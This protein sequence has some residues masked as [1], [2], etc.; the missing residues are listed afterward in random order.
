MNFLN[1]MLNVWVVL[2]LV[3]I[4]D[5]HM[6]ILNWQKPVLSAAEFS[7]NIENQYGIEKWERIGPE[8]GPVA[9]LAI[10]SADKDEIFV[11]NSGGIFKSTDGG[12]TWQETNSGI[13]YVG[14]S[15][16]KSAP[17]SP[18]TIYAASNN[19]LFKSVDSGLT[20][21]SI[22]TNWHNSITAIEIDPVN[23][24]II[25]IGLHDSGV[26]KSSD[27]GETWE[28][29]NQGL[30]NINVTSLSIDYSSLI[31]IYVG[32]DGG[33]VFVSKNDGESWTSMNDGLNMNVYSLAVDCGTSD[34]SIYA[35]TAGGVYKMTNEGGWTCLLQKSG[36]IYHNVIATHPTNADIVY[37]GSYHTLYKS[38]DAGQNW[39]VIGDSFGSIDGIGLHPDAPDRILI[40]SYQGIF[41]NGTDP[42]WI[43][44]KTG[45]T[46]T[47]V[48][49]LAFD[50][51]SSG[52]M[53]SATTYNGLL[54]TTDE[55]ESWKE[56]LDTYS[57]VSVAIDPVN[58]NTLFAATMGNGLYKSTNGGENWSEIRPSNN[59]VDDFDWIRQIVVGSDNPLNVYAGTD[60][61]IL[62]STDGGQNWSKP[63]INTSIFALALHS[64]KPEII[65]SGG[66]DGI[67]FK[68]TDSGETWDAGTELLPDESI[69]IW[70]LKIHPDEPDIIYACASIDGLFLSQDAGLNWRRVTATRAG[71][72]L[73]F[74]QEAQ[75]DILFIASGWNGV[76]KSL[77][78]GNNWFYEGLAPVF[79]RN[80]EKN[81]EEPNR[82]YAGTSGR[83]ISVY[84]HL[85]ASGIISGRVTRESDSQPIENFQVDAYSYDTGDKVFS[86]TFK[87][88][89]G[90][91]RIS[92]FPEGS[93]L[94]KVSVNDTNYISKYY[95]NVVNSL[96]ATPVI[97]IRNETTAGIDFS[98]STTDSTPPEEVTNLRVESYETSAVLKW[99]HSLD[100]EGD[101]AAY[102]VYFGDPAVVIT[103]DPSLNSFEFLNLAASSKQQVTIATIDNN[104][105]ESA[106]VSII[107]ATLLPNPGSVKAEEVGPQVE[108]SWNVVATE[109][110]VKQYAIYVSESDFTS[111]EGM[112]PR[113]LVDGSLLTAQIASL[114]AGTKYYFAVTA[115]NMS[116]ND[117]KEVTTVSAT[118]F[119]DILGPALGEIIMNNVVL[120]EGGK[121]IKGGSLTFMVDDV[122][123]VSRVDL[124]IDEV[125][126]A[127]DTS[128]AAS[129]QFGWDLR[130]IA[131]GDHKLVIKAYDSLG[132]ETIK[133][134]NIVI[135]LAAP[136]TAPT[137]IQPSD[138]TLFISPETLVSGQAEP[139]SDIILFFNNIESPYTGLVDQDGNFSLTAII[140][141]GENKIQALARNRAGDGPLSNEVM[142]SVD[143]TYPLPPANL[144]AAS[145][146]FGLI[147]LSWRRP[148]DSSMQGF[149]LYRSVSD[150]TSPDQ[151]D[152]L[153]SNTLT[154]T[155]Y[156][157][158][159]ASEGTYIYR[160]T[161]IDAAGRESELSDPVSAT[162]DATAP[163]VVAVVYTP[164][165]PYDSATGRT[166]PGEVSST[167]TLNE[168]LISDPFFSINPEGGTPIPVTLEKVSDLEYEGSFVIGP[169]T[170]TG[171]AYAVF[172]G[173]DL[174]GNRGIAINTGA[175][176]TIDT[177][178]PPLIE[179]ELQPGQP[180]RNDSTEP[181]SVTATFGLGEALGADETPTLFYTLSGH[182]G[183]TFP[184]ESIVQITTQSNHAQT[185]Q[186]SLTLSSDA[187]LDS[188]E[189]LQFVY[190]GKDDLGN[191]SNE[192][193]CTNQYQVYQGDLP[194]LAAPTDLK[195]RSLPGGLIALTW[196]AVE[197]SIGYDIFRQAPGE[198]E[199]T[200]YVRVE[201]TAQ[202]TDEPQADGIYTYAVASIRQEN[203]QEA[204]SGLSESVTAGSDS[205]LPEAPQNLVLELISQG[206]KADWQFDP[207]D[208]VTYSL[209]RSDQDEILSVEGLTPVL[210]GIDALWTIDSAPSAT[211]HCYAVTAIDAAG[212]ESGPSTSV[213]L[214]FELLPVSTLSVQKQ[215][216]TPPVVSWTLPNG[217]IAGCDLYL[218]PED[219]RI[220]LNS[221][222]LTQTD[223]TDSGFNGGV[224]IYT[225]VVKDD[226]GHESLGRSI[227]LPE[228]DTRLNSGENI[229]RN[230]MNSLEYQV[231]NPSTTAITNICINAVINDKH[232]RSSNFDL[233]PGE[234]KTVS[235]V[236]G[237]YSDLPDQ[238]SM[239]TI[240]EITPNTGEL[241][242]IS[243]PSDIEVNDGMLIAEILNDPFIRG[244]QGSARF[245]LENTGDHEIEIVTATKN[246]Q[247]NGQAWFK[248]LDEDENVLCSAALCQNLGLNVVT[249]SNGTTVARIPA[250]EI[251]TSDPVTLSVPANAPDTPTL[252]LAINN[253]YHHCG[254]DDQITLQ[255]I[256]T[257]HEIDLSETSYYG[258]ITTIL[259]ETSNGAQ[260]ITITGQAIQRSDDTP[261]A[262]V[263]L[264]L[265]ITVKNFT[266]TYQ[267]YTGDDGSFTYVFTP[268]AKEYGTYTV[269]AVHPDITDKPIQGQFVINRVVV[270]LPEVEDE[271]GVT[272]VWP[273]TVNLSIP[274]NYHQS[275]SIK[276]KAG[277]ED[278]TNLGLVYD[279]QDQP[280][281]TK[282]TG[283]HVDTG[284]PVEI[285]E[286]G[287][288]ATLTWSLWADNYSEDTGTIIL[289]I[290]SD[291][292]RPDDLGSLTVN[293]YFSEAQPALYFSPDHIETGMALDDRVLET[294]VFSNK[295]FGA[296][297]DVSLS[298]INEDGTPAPSWIALNTAEDL[299]DLEPG[300]QMEVNVSFNPGS[301]TVEEGLY[302]FY[303]RVNSANYPQTDILIFAAVTQSGVGNVQFKVSDIYTGTLDSATGELIQGLK[304]A[305][306]Y[307][308]NEEVPTVDASMT[309]DSLGEALFTDLPAGR[310]KYKITANDHGEETGR[311]WIKPGI[312]QNEQLFLMNNLVTV[313]WSVKE[314][315]IQDEY[316]I[317]LTVD[318]KTDVPVAVIVAEPAS[319]TLPVM[320]AGDVY[321]GEFM[322]T[323]YGLIRAKE[324]NYTLPSDNENFKYELLEGLPDSLESKERISV[325]YRVTCLKSVNQ[326][327]ETGSGG[328]SGGASGRISIDAK[329]D[330]NC[331]DLLSASHWIFPGYIAGAG[332]SSSGSVWDGTATGGIAGSG[333]S[334]LGGGVINIGVSNGTNGSSSGSGP[335]YETISGSDPCLPKSL[336][337]KSK[338]PESDSSIFKEV[339]CYVNCFSREFYDEN[340]DFAIKV[341]GGSVNVKRLYY[342]HEWHW[343]HTDNN[344]DM[345]ENFSNLS[346]EGLTETI[347]LGETII[348]DPIFRDHIDKG[349]VRYN[350]D[351]SSVTFLSNPV[352]VHDTNKIKF[353]SEEPFGFIW[354]DKF[355]N[356]K[357]Y[358]ILGRMTSYGTPAAI[359]GKLVYESGT[360][361]KL[362]GITDGDDRQVVWFEY[363]GD[364][365]SAVRD[366]TGRRVEYTYNGNDLLSDI[367]DVLGNDTSYEYDEY[368]RITKKTD[369][370]GRP[371][372]VSYNP[373]GDVSQVVDKDGN[374]HF[375]EFDYNETKDEFYALTRT[376]SGNIEEAWYDQEGDDLRVDINGRTIKT[377][378]KDGYNRTIT[379]E[380]GNVT[381]I[382]LD[383]W[384]DPVKIIYPDGSTLTLEYDLRFNKVSRRVTPRGVVTTYTYDETGNLIQKIEALGTDAERKTIYTYY[385]NTDLLETS[386]RQGDDRT[387]A[388]T[389]EF[390][391]DALGNL[392][393]VTDPMGHTMEILEHDN[394]GNPLKIKDF[395]NYTWTSTYDCLGRII[396]RQDPKGRQ[397]L[398]EY[399]EA[400]NLTAMIN[401]ALKRFEF[402]Y[403]DHNNQIKS[404]DPYGNAIENQYNTDN[405]LVKSID[406]EGKSIDFAYDKEKRLLNIIDGAGN[407]TG[408]NY[409]ESPD[410]AVSSYLPESVDYPTFTRQF[411]YDNLNRVTGQA[412]VLDQDTTHTRTFDYDQ[413]GNIVSVTDEEG[414]TTRFEYDAL[415]RVLKVVDP[416]GGEV[417]YT[418]D[419]RDNILEI[420]DP[421]NGITYFEYDKN[422]RLTRMTRP[423]FQETTY[424]YD[425]SGN[426]T[427]TVDA[428]GQR[429]EYVYDELDQ[430]TQVN[431]FATGDHSTPVKT[432]SFTYDTLGHL[433]SYVDGTT[434]AVYTYDDLH[435]KTT[436]TVDYGAFTLS[437]A[438][439]YYDNGLKK[440][441]TGP[442]GVTLTYTYDDNNR[443]TRIN[444]PGQGDVTRNTFQWNSPDKITL[445][446]GSTRTLSYDPLMQP[447][448]ISGKDPAQNEFFSRGYTYSP[449]GNITEKD[450][451]HGTYGYE[452][453]DLY[454]LTKAVNPTL[455]D[456]AYTYDARGNRITAEGISGNWTYNTN[457]ELQAY[458]DTSFEYDSNGNLNSKTVEG[459]T[460]YFIYD[461][462][463][464]MARV[465]DD[466]SNL[467][468]SYYY[469]PFGRRLWKDV[470]GG[471]TYFFYAEEGLIGEYEGS[472]NEIKSYGYV[473]DSIWTTG[474][475][476]LKTGGVYYWYQNDHLGTPQKLIGSNG[477][478]AWSGTYG[479]FGTIYNYTE[480]I[481]N[482]KFPGHYYDQETGFHYNWFRYYDPIIGRYCSIDPLRQTLNLYDFVHNNPINVIDPW[483]LC[484][485]EEMDELKDII[486]KYK[487]LVKEKRD[488]GWT[489]GPRGNVFD[490]W[491]AYLESE[492]KI[493]KESKFGRK[494]GMCND[495]SQFIKD[496]LWEENLDY[497][498]PKIGEQKL[499]LHYSAAIQLNSN[500][501]VI[502]ILDP[503][504][505][506]Q[507][508]IYTPEE[509]F[510][511]KID[512]PT[513]QPRVAQ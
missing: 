470:G 404:T 402:E 46:N 397:V 165:G 333:S 322:L 488:A 473:P 42:N 4:V 356:W 123:Q 44:L 266:R 227:T 153:N 430:L 509:W 384:D 85:D 125:L 51:N 269:R 501:D 160:V 240:I 258:L 450:T 297:T 239:T 310:Y 392:T 417:V 270:E 215:A 133:E 17:Q 481:N 176:L 441:F 433:T 395:R 108:M 289:R 272:T 213:Y 243:E 237:G 11:G 197:E 278:L 146:E 97:V 405:L 428:K 164:Q 500:P 228:I 222:L 183:T 154:S 136:S 432:I 455:D 360:D 76:L 119:S 92:G 296:L 126:I 311:V 439:T 75:P 414:K 257:T 451:E 292:S 362:T 121:I 253:L 29:T 368:G 110:L 345:Y 446:G 180:I 318:F 189:T 300:D 282:P 359:L 33:G 135:A 214:N 431:H 196:T 224:R 506:G 448:S 48:N 502:L 174:A 419:N 262:G 306:I 149:N 382:T 466:S 55:G 148:S 173:R 210:T 304:G 162:S 401:A 13:S 355:G 476:F 58:S 218:G 482:L 84:N 350:L 483:G 294:I 429:L 194:P 114:A 415:N 490:N 204:V 385:E 464:R 63:L 177:R 305:R 511:S 467:I 275:I 167:L 221:D 209:Y 358:N 56:V 320:V 317:V 118:P 98:L 365:I 26:Y 485:D 230:V 312:T 175:T 458:G 468:V 267:V 191:V 427:A 35:A 438:Y 410:T 211:H 343:W 120:V 495:W 273:H 324:M 357:K 77:D 327:E 178:G 254:Q 276:V 498:T 251:F 388:A 406:R 480:I 379:D 387:E 216:D 453:D 25:Y 370:A 179:V 111:V 507:P 248:L 32:T 332:S 484:S 78:G 200:F 238:V 193:T 22:V 366:N 302:Y 381:Q 52:V 491:G 374:G 505:N 372:L 219:S 207:D 259:P 7:V 284:T 426:R 50:K 373:Y 325:P 27:G 104:G 205:T 247:A 391:Y 117:R 142:V 116:G 471:R 323:N 346:T 131:D 244:G 396:S 169:T 23:S 354:K 144:T 91:Y 99:D 487:K 437:Y 18:S 88:L 2:F 15:V 212:N 445:P 105:N 57:M 147:R 67:V 53:Y 412:D 301:D 71:D 186:G 308:Q 137:I 393:M 103:I 170:P 363:E 287:Q 378:V 134:I 274:R 369:A 80:L 122:S 231:G 425:E 70:R 497:W 336:L 416:A 81:P 14:I 444:I 338:S 293:M 418:Y 440:S 96:S 424:E 250:G 185:W 245:T 283:V 171:T 364:R 12:E 435:R 151:A 400:N 443:L 489:Y 64:A 226:S 235:V 150:F 477:N 168:P 394:M 152:Q 329:S 256:Q 420:K 184:I 161:S 298:L 349:G 499:G 371:T 79:I 127:S 72:I 246:G 39:V 139:C 102:K 192:I 457:N 66:G 449:A 233:E 494:G 220:K 41:K 331:D 24:N 34:K 217:N 61:G 73:I 281:E 409:D 188:A 454:R 19:R 138:G 16:L 508:E 232:H 344:L 513:S 83:G 74:P 386:T 252:E 462:A 314:T 140:N 399:D 223:Y 187:G 271:P 65:Y 315:T 157:D 159:P 478:V 263:P 367:K 241:V 407:K 62:K 198:T 9:A 469:D 390:S 268:M 109:T 279:A 330:S 69:S 93:Y 20:W 375:F 299:E 479:S 10:S 307:V 342:D 351:T 28:E 163:H 124:S 442:D 377:L 503:W 203:D 389:V 303:L 461:T 236:V 115:V 113:H 492:Y 496:E 21:E 106:G 130:T 158:I 141:E 38:T 202:Y 37:F 264:R 40:E 434:S 380:K 277:V 206:I 459:Q 295:G 335:G 280:E 45:L 249:L 340:I 31:T 486:E 421:N 190:Q 95:D 101:L 383:E 132:N 290:K 129:V 54:K 229:S 339:G 411:T 326:E 465:E 208:S 261:M 172:S 234:T 361:G 47:I 145:K 1:R 288:T 413:A 82:I 68:S 493:P 512:E 456:E 328:G 128:G 5:T 422:S 347:S 89:D 87:N 59:S 8:G 3:S 49:S 398:F 155:I 100:S 423:L 352:Y 43:E 334:N 260:D 285:L 265:E 60:G 475:V 376:S 408:Y 474:P 510:F 36:S 143:A 166:G 504:W 6:G 337:E 291:E 403:D 436:E 472:G 316:E 348:I 225:V 30:T 309:T 319:V 463:N 321:Q 353:V 447:L 181:V 195:A 452:Y 86:Y 182:T 255:G 313:E 199:L 94:I 90:S 112:T 460:T 107:A 242:E 156:N 201:G 341:S 286:S